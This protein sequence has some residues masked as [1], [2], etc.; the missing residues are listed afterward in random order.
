VVSW[1][2]GRNLV[3]RLRIL[4][5]FGLAYAG[6]VFLTNLIP[7]LGLARH[8]RSIP[9]LPE[10]VLRLTD[11]PRLSIIVPARNEEQGVRAAVESLLRQDYPALELIVVD[12]RS[13]DRTGAILAG[14]AAEHPGRLRVLHVTELPAGWLGKNYALWLG[15]CESSGEWLLFTDADVI[16]DPACLR[17]A[18]ACAEA[19]KLDHVTMS[20]LLLARGYWLN[21]FVN[22]FLYAFTVFLRPDLA[23]DPQSRGGIGVGAFNLIRRAA[24][25]RVG[26]HQAISL[27]PD[28]DMRLGKRVKLA[29]LR[30]RVVNGA[31]VLSVRWYATLGEAIRGL[32]KNTFAGAEYRVPAVVGGVA[33]LAG[34]LAAPW[35]L[36]WITRGWTRRLLAATIAVQS[37]TYGGANGLNRRPVLRYLPSFPFAAL[38]FCYVA[39]RSTWLTLRQGG[40]RWRDTLYPLAELR[41]QT[42]LEGLSGCAH[43]SERGEGHRRGGER[44]RG[45]GR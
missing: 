19:Q 16:F 33:V 3:R 8:A 45:G 18:V 35:A 24:Y 17:R 34:M 32:E 30:Q 28:D 23:N 29:G 5:L 27:R 25:A 39:L 42:G 10:S 15:A 1:L 37:L 13:T 4:P 36:V 31:D 44:Q 40:I 21:A 26:T 9:R 12:D 11:W 41:A 20:P 2:E 6:A 43:E 7:F 38:L 22:F 14:L